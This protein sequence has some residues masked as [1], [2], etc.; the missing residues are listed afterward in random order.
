[1]PQPSRQARPNTRA[2]ASNPTPGTRP[3]SSSRSQSRQRSGEPGG[4][5]DFMAKVPSPVV[6]LPTA[7]EV[8]TAGP[9]VAVRNSISLICYIL[10]QV[11]NASGAIPRL[12]HRAVGSGAG[13]AEH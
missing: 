13:P 8:S 5:F 10:I 9:T 12:T 3:P 11:C 4:P 2:M 7:P 6:P 1:M